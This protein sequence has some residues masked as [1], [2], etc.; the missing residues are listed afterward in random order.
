MSAKLCREG[1]LRGTQVQGAWFVEEASIAEFVA[2]RAQ[3]KLERSEELARLRREE[4]SAFRKEHGLEI[5][6]VSAP[7]PG[8]S[9]VE[10]LFDRILPALGSRVALTLGAFLIFGAVALASGAGF[11][12]QRAQLAAAIA[13]IDSP[14]FGA[15][16]PNVTSTSGSSSLTSNIFS[17]ILGFF[18]GNNKNTQVASLPTTQTT[19]STAVT[20]PVTAPVVAVAT[21]VATPV[22]TP[23]QAR[24][25]QTPIVQNVTNPVVERTVEHVV[26][27]VSEELLA[28]KLSELEN[29]LRQEISRAISGVSTPI[30][31]NYAGGGTT[32]NIALTQRIDHLD[33]VT[34]T[35][36]IITDSTINGTTGGGG[37]GSVN[38]TGSAGLL[39]YWSDASTLAA[40]STVTAD[41]LTITSPLAT[42]TFAGNIAVGGYLQTNVINCNQDLETDANGLIVCGIDQ[43]AAG[44][45]NP[46]IWGQNYG[47][48]AAATTSPFW[49]Q[50]GLF[51]SSTSHFA[52]VDFVNAT[53]SSFYI[54]G[55]N[56]VLGAT[57]GQIGTI[58][59][60]TLGLLASS[61]ISATAP[62]SY[63]ANTGVF[64]I[65]QAG[66]STDGYLSSADFNAFNAR[67]STSTL[68]LIDKGS[69]FS[70]T[71]ANYFINASTTIPHALG[72]A[73]GDVFIWNGSSWITT[74]TSTL[75]ITSSGGSTFGKSW[76]IAGTYLAP[77]TTIGIIISASSTINGNLTITGNS[78]T[79]NATTTN[80]AISGTAST[81]RLYGA[82]LASC[83]GGNVL[84]WNNGFFGCVADQTSAGQANPFIFHHKLRQHR[85]AATSSPIWA[86][87]GIFASSTSYFAN[88]LFTN[89]T[90]SNLASVRST[91]RSKQT[92]A[93]FLQPRRSVC[94]TAVRALPRQ[95]TASSW[96]GIRWRV[97]THCNLARLGFLS[98]ANRDWQV[99]NG[100][101][102]PTSTI[103]IMV[104]ASSTIGNSTAG[105]GLT[106]SG[107]ATTTGLLHVS[108]TGTSTINTNIAMGGNIVPCLNQHLHTWRFFSHMERG[109][110]RPRLALR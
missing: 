61:S 66:A 17:G 32:N 34:I 5:Q 94:S 29:A 49:A 31:P 70:T 92:T 75:G 53:T 100:Y 68:A 47:V 106:I 59:T 107:D 25:T 74:A 51:A 104:L 4:S 40:T 19:P 98:A 60:N 90:T 33:G 50:N 46:F 76:E 65:A 83:Q 84:T 39:A 23:T 55:L 105:G 24:P 9:F 110:H 102:T 38:G 35:H 15:H 71:S 18:F 95:T 72:A 42:S 26:S 7:V 91:A 14:F 43:T 20:K 52:N 6:S 82:G 8:A 62:L 28:S 36:A 69:F 58:A 109:F 54:R 87:S 13:Q 86:Q 67:L 64:S 96:W 56:G 63:N 12:D 1:K 21:P 79:T 41:Y 81:T 101:L 11:T 73:Y 108:G 93:L 97:H 57:N 48:V 27:G 45:A 88:A 78:T 2:V 30:N 85:G 80:L 16:L 89:A 22:V 3:S 37:T 99:T 103:G 77:T 10:R 44:Q